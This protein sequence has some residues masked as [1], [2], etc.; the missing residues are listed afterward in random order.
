MTVSMSMATRASS[1]VHTIMV[2]RHLLPAVRP[3]KDQEEGREGEWHRKANGVG[4]RVDWA[5]ERDR[6]SS[7]GA[8]QFLTLFPRPD[9]PSPLNVVCRSKLSHGGSG[10]LPLEN[11]DFLSLNVMLAPLH[12]YAGS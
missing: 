3:C 10:G 4:K 11:K 5:W 12:H 6:F 1:Q 8:C 9:P 2:T 7:I